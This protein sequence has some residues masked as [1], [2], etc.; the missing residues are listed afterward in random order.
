MKKILLV[1]LACLLCFFAGYF[2]GSKSRPVN[3]RFSNP[4]RPITMPRRIII[5]KLPNNVSAIRKLPKQTIA[6]KTI[7]TNKTNIQTK[8]VVKQNKK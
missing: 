8:T 3:K 5:P 4:Y 6:T 7:P 2:A 1:V